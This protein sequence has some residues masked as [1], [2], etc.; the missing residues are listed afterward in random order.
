MRSI[1]SAAA[2][3]GTSSTI[4]CRPTRRFWEPNRQNSGNNRETLSGTG[5]NDS[6]LDQA[7]ANRVTDQVGKI[8]NSQFVHQPVAMASRCFETH[9][10]K[11]GSLLG[12]VP[13]G[14]AL[15]NI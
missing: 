15:Q 3:T 2:K 9:A 7:L 8:V 4:G 11:I 1:W 12:A 14:D 10:Q 5:T 6:G 13:L